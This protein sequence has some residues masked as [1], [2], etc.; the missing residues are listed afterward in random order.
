MKIIADENIPFAAQACE[1]VGDVVLTSG[2]AFTR[3]L[4]KDADALLAPRSTGQE[5][6]APPPVSDRYPGALPG[7]SPLAS[8]GHQP[9]PAP[10]LD[11]EDGHPGLQPGARPGRGWSPPVAALRALAPEEPSRRGGDCPGVRSCESGRASA[12][13][14]LPYRGERRRCEAARLRKPDS[15][16]A[17]GFCIV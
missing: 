16:V 4:V 17:T 3:E 8:A 9:G 2:R 14:L 11:D 12:R 6:Y 13:H 15:P 10:P 7:S 1:T 5:H